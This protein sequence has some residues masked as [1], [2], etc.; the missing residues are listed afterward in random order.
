[1]SCA[2]PT[3]SA[4]A[5]PCAARSTGWPT[6]CRKSPTSWPTPIS[7]MPSPA[8]PDN[9]AAKPL[10]PPV[11]TPP[12]RYRTRHTTRYRY[13]E[14]VSVSQHIIHLAPRDNPR[15]ECSS[16]T[17]SISPEPSIRQAWLDYFGNPAEYFAVQEPHR[18]LVIESTVELEVSQPTP[19]DAAATPAWHQ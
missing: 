11:E 14:G 16:V 18:E 10:A 6:G 1:M 13:G 19:L 15:Q 3:S 7:A 2:S 17:L 8:P 12:V 4:T 5:S 9:P